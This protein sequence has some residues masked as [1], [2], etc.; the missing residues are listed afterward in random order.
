MKL[1]VPNM[2]LFTGKVMAVVGECKLGGWWKGRKF[3]N[4]MHLS[5][6]CELS[7]LSRTQLDMKTF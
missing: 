4:S 3:A 7:R 2:K 6:L 1:L 5:D